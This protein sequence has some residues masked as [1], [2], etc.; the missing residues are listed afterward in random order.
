ML[1]EETQQI[2]CNL[3]IAIAKGERNI[4]I[5]RQ[6]LSN[7]FNFSPYIIFFHLSN[8]NSKQIT[9]NDIYTYLNSKD[10]P[11]TETE[12]KLILLFYDK[13]LDNNLTFDEFFNFIQNKNDDK[14]GKN[15]TNLNFPKIS[16]LG[17]NIEFLLLKLFSKEIE[18]AKKI[19]NFLKKLKYRQ[20]FDIHKIFHYMTNNNF[21]NKYCL[22]K[23]FDKNNN[24]YL[25]S[26]IKNI[27][28]RLDINK[29]GIIDLR[30][31]YA[32]LQFPNS[33]DNYYRFVPCNI[34]REKLC[35]KCLYKNNTNININSNILLNSNEINNDITLSPNSNKNY[36]LY[37]I[38]CCSNKDL[39]KDNNILLKSQPLFNSQSYLDYNFNSNDFNNNSN[40]KTLRHE[41]I[42]GKNIIDENKKIRYNSPLIYTLRTKLS[43]LKNKKNMEENPYYKVYPKNLLSPRIKSYYI[44]IIDSCFN[45]KSDSIALDIEK[46]NNFLKLVMQKEIE[47]EKEKINFMKSTDLN[48]DDIFN[49]F[50]KD[51]KEYI[52]IPDLKAGFGILEISKNDIELNLFMNRYDLK[53]QKKLYKLDFFDAVA[54]FEKEY[55]I[56]M[57]NKNKEKNEIIEKIEKIDIDIDKQDNLLHNKLNVFYLK[58]L[59]TIIIDKEKE[60]NEYKKSFYDLKDKLN[61]IFKLIDKD[62]KGYFTFSDLNAYLEKYRL[63]FDS[64]S[65]AL[66]FIR[67]DK[68]RQGKPTLMD[69]LEEMKPLKS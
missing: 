16:S 1:T 43:Y 50:D 7:S 25:E 63:I 67:F 54:P 17:S 35:D 21:I 26:D 41:R 57:E 2:L 60:I 23:F 22:Q 68:K 49:F 42:Y 40:Y 64:F 15:S 37:S 39:S 4:K 56:I 55:R 18:L 29:D 62:N 66:L 58:K 45:P 38:N 44:N 65:V 46:F 20:D 48:F 31:F 24:D 61:K 33:A 11:I 19:L 69:M 27:I 14:T 3:F 59:Y 51:K 47:I 12:S 9:S 34:C 13:N 32:L 52:S 30:E 10:I 6:V 53:K 36:N 28:R 5:T 8:Y